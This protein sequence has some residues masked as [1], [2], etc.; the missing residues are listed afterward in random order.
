M[1]APDDSLLDALH[2]WPD[3]ALWVGY[4]GGMDSTVLLHALAQRGAG[5]G[6]T[7]GA[8]HVHHGLSAQADAWAAHCEATCQAVGVGLRVVRVQVDAGSGRGPEAAAREARRA[9][10]ASVLAPGDVL[11]LAHHQNDQAETWL[12]RALRGSGPDGLAAMRSWSMAGPLHLWRPWL[13]VPRADLQAYAARHGLRWI[14]DPSNADTRLDRN[15]LRHAVMPALAARW[16]HAG[17]ALAQSAAQCADAAA[18][19]DEE[20]AHALAQARTLDPATLRIDPLRG[21]PA[22]RRAR[23]LRRWIR[24][25]GLPPL[26]RR[27]VEAA[28]AH[29]EARRDAQP[30]FDWHGTRLQAWNGLLRAA[31]IVAPLAADWRAQWDGAAPLTLPGGGTLALVG[32]PA[33][34]APVQ[35][36]ARR[37]GERITLPGRTHSHALKHVLQDLGVPPWVRARLPLLCGADGAVVAGADL[38]YA[39]GFDAGLRARGAR[40]HWDD[41][42]SH[43]GD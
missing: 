43:A 41:P 33:F 35:V 36:R 25:C 40:L 27:G 11:A 34:D 3:T 23:V 2:P 5:T 7:L 19:L 17:A 18:V 31:P 16:P 20:D 10:F 8:V 22:L 21:L 37:G 38:V 39:A 32:A 15:H 29:M 12:L 42:A 30:V 28:E 4:S 1:P 6:R 9:A 14:D 24:D 26:P 13:A